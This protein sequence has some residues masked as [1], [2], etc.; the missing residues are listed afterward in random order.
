MS[1]NFQF[2]KV[3]IVSIN[4]DAVGYPKKILLEMS[5]FS[6]IKNKSNKNKEN[7]TKRQI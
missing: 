5:G 7:E 3:N 4:P 2:M 6:G 1:Q